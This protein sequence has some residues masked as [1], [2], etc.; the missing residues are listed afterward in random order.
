MMN[1]SDAWIAEDPIPALNAGVSREDHL[2][3]TQRGACPA[4][5][6][7]ADPRQ[8]R[9]RGRWESRTSAGLAHIHVTVSF[10]AFARE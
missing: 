3:P 8:A 5:D 4:G 6:G 1:P 10:D 2:L 9:P 7:P